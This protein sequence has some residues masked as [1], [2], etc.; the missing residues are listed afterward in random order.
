VSG[1]PARRIPVAI[2]GGFLGSGK[3]TL[4][5]ESLTGDPR[6][7]V[8]V[9]EFGAEGFD[10][11]LLRGCEERIELVSGG[12]ACCGR[13]ADLVEVLRELLDGH[14]RGL[15]PLRRVVIETSGLADPA[16]IV[17]TVSSQAMLRHH[18]AIERLTVCVDA[19]NGLDQ[20]AAHDEAVKQ[21]AVAD[22]LVITKLDLVPPAR[23]DEL[24]ARLR[25]LNGQ[26]SIIGARH[27]VR[28]IGA[29]S[30][31]RG[32]QRAPRAVTGAGH[33]ADVSSTLVCPQRESDWLGFAVWLSMLL[34]ASGERVLR[35]KGLLELDDTTFVAING[36]QHTIHEP[37]HLRADEVPAGRPGVLFITRGL[38]TAALEAS[39]EVFQCAARA[40]APAGP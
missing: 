23:R 35:V 39:F 37:E 25:E 11:R 22:E 4:L 32:G 38:D 9:N 15:A 5:R 36:V 31:A 19:V 3:T 24:V 14:E 12:C 6:T 16:P 26:A 1:P 20:L 17:A 21:A 27:G 33:A 13:R 30:A 29:L 34:A 18:F 7:A 10:H 40:P 2:V 8:I 28:E